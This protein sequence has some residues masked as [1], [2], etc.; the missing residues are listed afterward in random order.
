VRQ[1]R[2]EIVMSRDGRTVYTIGGIDERSAIAVLARDGKT[3]LLRQLPG[4]AGCLLRSAGGCASA[5]LNNPVALIVT[6]DGR[7]VV[8]TNPPAEQTVVAYARSLRTGALSELRCSG[9]CKAVRAAPCADGLA[10]SPDARTV[11]VSSAYC[12]G[13]GFA[14]L[15]RDPATGQLSQPAGAAGCIQRIGA[16]G[17]AKAPVTAF[18]P[19]EPIVTPD[20]RTVYVRS[21]S[22]N[23]GLFAFR[24]NPATG[25]LTAGPC[26]LERPEPPCGKLEQRVVALALSPEGKSLYATTQARSLEDRLVPSNLVNFARDVRSGALTKIAETPIANS[27]AAVPTVSPDGRTVYVAADDRS[28]SATNGSRLLAFARAAT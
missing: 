5:P 4:R 11:Y 25:T 12:A 17:C 21:I 8:W 6:P 18:A 28:L 24:R 15:A 13:H 14:V 22:S 23:G 1:L 27:T 10:S 20:G 9:V 3:G 2:S 26:Y 16:D 7:E 19:R